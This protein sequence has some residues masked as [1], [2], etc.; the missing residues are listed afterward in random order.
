MSHY[1]CEK[2]MKKGPPKPS[3]SCDRRKRYNS[4]KVSKI[5]E[6]MA[7]PVFPRNAISLPC[8]TL[9]EGGNSVF[10]KLLGNAQ[11]VPSLLSP[12][13]VFLRQPRFPGGETILICRRRRPPYAFSSQ[14]PCG[15]GFTNFEVTYSDGKC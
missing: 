2:K 12:N 13:P 6:I 5:R 7:P 10:R 11:L 4:N 1:I 14:L 8:P 3:P 9:R 15:V